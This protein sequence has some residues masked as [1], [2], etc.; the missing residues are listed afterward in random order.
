MLIFLSW[1]ERS[2]LL[3]LNAT[4]ERKELRLE[5]SKDLAEDKSAAVDDLEYH[6]ASDVAFYHFTLNH[7]TITTTFDQIA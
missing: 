1:G 6:Y 4:F 2:I 3:T 5:F 7:D